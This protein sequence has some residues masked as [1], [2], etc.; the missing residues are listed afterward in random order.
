MN[1]NDMKISKM[2]MA[3]KSYIWKDEEYS[4][5]INEIDPNSEEFLIFE[6]LYIG[7]LR[8]GEALALTPMD[9]NFK[10][11]ALNINKSLTYVNNKAVITSTKGLNDNRTIQL[12]KNF[13]NNI[14][15]FIKNNNEIKT[16]NIMFSTSRYQLKRILDEKC[17]NLNLPH[18]SLL[19]FRKTYKEK[20][21][22]KKIFGIAKSY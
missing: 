16:N 1:K 6:L 21:L 5:F 22:E 8:V 7:G 2:K 20:Q 13:L 12:P 18:R 11:N 4:L 15:V 14:E 10:E 19:S 9:F 17:K 3:D